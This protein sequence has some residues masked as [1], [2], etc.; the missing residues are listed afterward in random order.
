MRSSI[1]ARSP[2]A[3][4]VALAALAGTLCVLAA[5]TAHARDDRVALDFRVSRTA[6]RFQSHA[7]DSLGLSVT[8]GYVAG[9]H[10]DFH[11]M[12][13]PMKAPQRP[14]LHVYGTALYNT[15]R[16]FVSAPG[17]PGGPEFTMRSPMLEVYGGIGFAVP[18]GVV[19]QTTGAQFTLRYDGGVVIAA[20]TG[21][22]FIQVSK[23]N[24]GF[25]RTGGVFHGSAIEVGYGH[26]ERFGPTWAPKRWS[27][28]MKLFTALSHVPAAPSGAAGA[29]PGPA[30]AGAPLRAFVT[31]DLDTDGRPGPDS[32]AGQFGFAFDVGALLGGFARAFGS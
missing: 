32:L 23:L 24:A 16:V 5:G 31:L 4:G 21:E 17:G 1:P 13:V 10:M 9:V 2:A 18:M 30:P 29:K 12:D 7:A 14:A 22:N 8:F 28:R 3:R 20:D 26:D 11:V 19:D 15:D 25:E 27:A 6:E